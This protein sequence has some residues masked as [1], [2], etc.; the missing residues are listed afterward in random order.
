MRG[1]IWKIPAEGGEAIA[2]TSGPA[3]YFEPAWSPDGARIAFAFEATGNL[4]I[5]IVSANGGPVETVASHERVDIQPA[6][7]RDGKSLF[8]VSARSGAFRIFRHDFAANTDT[9]VTN[10]IQPAVSPDGKF[11]AYEQSGLRV[12]DL[13]TGESRMVRDEETE[14][15]MEPAWTPDG[16]SILYVTEDEGSN[17]IRIVSA[18]GGDPIEL[19]NDT[20]RHEMSPSVSP[21]GTKFAFVQFDAG[22]RRS[23]PLRLPAG[24]RAHGGRFRSPNVEV[25]RP[26]AACASGW[27]DPTGSPLARASTS[28]R[29]TD[30]ITRL[31]TAFIGR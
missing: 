16:Q 12:L 27:W 24:V 15:R 4:D 25:L 18:S 1:D 3:Y 26:P 5:G 23:I 28:T 29:A 13:A 2:L 7:S 30:G 10:G 11:L 21:D 14:Y 8:F 19:T 20:T 17:D 6:W 22:V 31:T 9:A